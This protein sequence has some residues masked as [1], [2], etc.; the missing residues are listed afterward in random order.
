MEFIRQGK[1]KVLSL[2]KFS[3]SL[4]GRV[5]LF[6]LLPITWKELK[7]EWTGEN[8]AFDLIYMGMYPRLY[9]Q[10][11]SPELFYPSYI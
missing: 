9:D 5:V 3:Q 1:G 4:A 10:N 2:T 8:T 6:N 7:A 11:V